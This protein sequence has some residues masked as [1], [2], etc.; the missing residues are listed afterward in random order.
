MIRPLGP[1][2][3]ISQPIPATVK[4]GDS[5]RLGDLT[6]TFERERRF[7]VLQ[8]ARNP[9]IPIFF[10]AAILLIGG[11]MV[12]FYFPHRRFRGNVTATPAGS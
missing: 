4:Q 2:S 7:S 3:P 10:V 9:G 1:E 6:L 8:V 5:V 12:T 11:S